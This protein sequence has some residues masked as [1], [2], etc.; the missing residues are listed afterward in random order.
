MKK[1]NPV[2]KI[3]ERYLRNRY[4]QEMEEKVQR[5]LID[6]NREAEKNQSLEAY[7]NSLP[8][9]ASPATHSSL[10]QVKKRLGMANS[11]ST[12]RISMR[13][14][15]LR[16]AAVIFP[17]VLLTG[18][19]FLMKN[20]DEKRNATVSIS[21]PYGE[22]RKI[23]LPDASTV[24]LNAGSE[25]RYA[26]SFG[27]TA[28]GVKL[29]GEACFSVAKDPAK[30]FIVETKHLSVEVLGTEFN[31]KAYPDETET[32][33]TLN[34]GRIKATTKTGRAYTLRP[35]QQLH[36]DSRSNSVALAQVNAGDFSA[37][38]DGRLVFAGQPLGTILSA[39]ER[40]FDVAF[41]TGKTLDVGERY[42]LKF[43]HNESFSEIMRILETT[44]GIDYRMENKTVWLTKK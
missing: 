41:Q 13:R 38:K 4:N 32:T 25:I 34:R 12:E 8:E 20:L 29:S 23:T 42:S 44:A 37:W 18:S 17:F 15:W 21:V 10:S 31:V 39:I 22:S 33:A 36:Y 16:I 14:Q 3:I 6:K 7:W 19:Y 26:A 35:N 28:R 43:L 5:W 30:P 40:K 24:F 11:V 2:S 1:Q 9:T 27:K